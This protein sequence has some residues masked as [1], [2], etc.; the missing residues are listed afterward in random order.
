MFEGARLLFG[1]ILE[2]A[3]T[4]SFLPQQQPRTTIYLIWHHLKSLMLRISSQLSLCLSLFESLWD[5]SSALFFAAFDDRDGV[6]SHGHLQPRLAQM[7]MLLSTLRYAILAG[8]IS[9]NITIFNTRRLA[10]DYRY[11]DAGNF[12][13]GIDT[14]E[15]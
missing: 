9:H 4:L 2:R 14:S 5:F 12:E 8:S 3:R 15:L 13:A 7:E 6:L 11:S 1:F 10:L